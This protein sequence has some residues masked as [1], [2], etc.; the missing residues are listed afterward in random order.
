M[1]ASHA[2][3]ARIIE[4]ACPNVRI[5]DSD[6]AANLKSLGV[7]SLD[8]AIIFLNISEELDVMVPDADIDALD[9]VERIAAYVA[10]HGPA[11]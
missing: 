8:T 1:S 7:D 4:T 11:A 10:E 5:A 9:T 6:Y 3:I 2:D